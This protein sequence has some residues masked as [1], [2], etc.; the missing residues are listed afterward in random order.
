MPWD[1]H[2][3]TAACPAAGDTEWAAFRWESFGAFP[4]AA[5]MLPAKVDGV[6]CFVQLDTGANGRFISSGR[7]VADAPGREVAIEIG[8]HTVTAR[9]PQAVLAALP[10]SGDCHAGTVGNA[11]FENGSLVLDLTASHSARPAGATKS[12]ARPAA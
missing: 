4:H 9:V 12:A 3:Q 2:E 11:F 7:A 10:A 1:D 5:L 6:A 8:H